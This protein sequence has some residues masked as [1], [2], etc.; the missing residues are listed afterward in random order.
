MT[1]FFIAKR[2]LHSKHKINFI[3]IISWFSAFGITIGVAA[4]VIVLSVFNGFGTIVK[5]ILVNFDPNVRITFTSEK[6]LGKAASIGKYLSSNKEI[7]SFTPFVEGR[8]VIF[9]GEHFEIIN[10]K[11]MSESFSNADWGLSTRIISGSAKLGKRNSHPSIILGL[12]IALKLGVRTGDKVSVISAAQIQRS[13]FSYSFPE[14]RQYYVTGIFDINNKEYASGYA[15][16]LLQ[17]AQSTL[18]TGNIF[19]G[20]EIR[21]KDISKSD[22]IK[23]ELIK[24]FGSEFLKVE[25]WYDLHKNLYNVMLMERWA[26]YF[27]LSLIIAVATFNILSSLTMSAMEKK[28]D[29][30][31]LRSM[32]LTKKGIKKIFVY[33]GVLI[34]FAGTVLGIAIGLLLCYIQ[35]HY[36]IYP[37]DASKYIIDSLPVQVRLTDVAVISLMSFLLTYLASLYPAKQS[38]KTN[39]IQAIKWE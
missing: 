16:T 39:I 12:P 23:D 27:I 30:A 33:Q 21:L 38:L 2:Y 1:E 22:K 14:A 28:R 31:V 20:F 18:K 11:G 36:N 32:G 17:N 24:K 25:T 35:I 26:A 10:L 34:G 19:N 5:D 29:I 7:T 13:A 8:V 37:L 3:S 6:A 15:Y 9:N 4:L